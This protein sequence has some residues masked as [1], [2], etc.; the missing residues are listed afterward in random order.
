MFTCFFFLITLH[1][2]SVKK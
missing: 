1:V 2:N